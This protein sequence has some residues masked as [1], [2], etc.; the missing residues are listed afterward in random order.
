MNLEESRFRDLLNDPPFDGTYRDEHRQQLRQ[1]VLEAFDAVQVDLPG[2]AIRNTFSHWRGI[3]SRPIPRVAAVVLA[4]VT[5]CVVFG[6][7]LR[8][9]PTVAFGSLIDPILNAK[10][11]RFNM[12]VEMS[13]P[14]EPPP[15]GLLS[16]NQ[17]GF[18][19]RCPWV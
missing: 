12:V 19:R 8:T 9:Q 2:R 16:L 15:S 17:I 14:A 7:I 11:A 4:M 18:D 10:S 13:G 1:Q 6:V 5:A 3:M